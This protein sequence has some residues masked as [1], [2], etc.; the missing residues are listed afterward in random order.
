MIEYI[1]LAIFGVG[2]FTASFIY[3]SVIGTKILYSDKLKEMRKNKDE[4]INIIN[5]RL[6]NLDF[7]NKK[8]SDEYKTL[9]VLLHDLCKIK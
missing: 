5:A 7:E 6:Y 9:N 8:E 2:T 4:L 3:L 1:C